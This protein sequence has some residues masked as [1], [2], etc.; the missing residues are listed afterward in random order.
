MMDSVPRTWQSWLH[1]RQLNIKMMAMLVAWK[2]WLVIFTCQSWQVLKLFP[3]VACTQLSNSSLPVQH[4][5]SGWTQFI[6]L[7]LTNGNLGWCQKYY[8]IFT[9]INSW[10][11][12]KVVFFSA[13]ANTQLSVV[14]SW[15]ILSLFQ[16]LLK[17]TRFQWCITFSFCVLL[18]TCHCLQFNCKCVKPL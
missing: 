7:H 16:C 17:E 4:E 8:V 3:S 10:H 9:H 6:S 15:L 5:H 18:L 11:L 14:N 13:F 12:K 2:I 1:R